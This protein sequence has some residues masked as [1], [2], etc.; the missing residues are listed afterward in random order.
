MNTITR[1]G[2]LGLGEVGSRLAADLDKTGRLQ[3]QA[4][5]RLFSDP[6][7]KP[8]DTLRRLPRI[9]PAA[10]AASAAVGCDLVIS[11][12]TAGQ[13]LIATQSVLPGTEAGAWF[14]DLNSVSPGSK[15]AVGDVV[16]QAGVRYVEAA[17]MSPIEPLGIGSPILCGGP[18]ARAFLPLATSLGFSGMRLCSEVLGQA[19]ATKMC[20]SVVVKGMEA[21]LTEALL[22]ARHYGVEDEVIASLS[23]MFPHPEWQQKATYMISRSL[24]HGARRAE[25]MDEATRTVQEAGF[26]PLM[27]AACARRQA[28]AAQYSRALQHEELAAM[29]DA[30][31]ALDQDQRPGVNTA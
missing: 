24:L 20:R 31:I 28:W 5:D 29:L 6:A 12:V 3:L 25:E 17:V 30:I 19:A 1:I 27:S 13:D 18:H 10:D 15:Q 21:L 7:S 14:L 26:E 11:A 8:A 2:L 4:W 16:A 9:R 23:N 22:A